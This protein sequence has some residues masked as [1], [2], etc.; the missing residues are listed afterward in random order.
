[1]RK[2]IELP[3]SKNVAGNEQR[4][5]SFERMFLGT[6]RKCEH[7]YQIYISIISFFCSFLSLMF[8]ALHLFCWRICG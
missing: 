1:V 7:F 4:E 8:I 3:L 2:T 6:F 5:I